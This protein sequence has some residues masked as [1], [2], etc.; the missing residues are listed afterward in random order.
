MCQKMFLAVVARG[1][2]N[3][4]P[5]WMI[6]QRDAG[7]HIRMVHCRLLRRSN[8]FLAELLTKLFALGPYIRR[9]SR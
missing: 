2:M 6:L 3:L 4:S 7:S 8:D 1:V 9:Y 5:A